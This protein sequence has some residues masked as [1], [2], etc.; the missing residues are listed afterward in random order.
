MPSQVLACTVSE[1][2]GFRY[3]ARLAPVARP[4]HT[5]SLTISS[6]WSRAHDPA[7]EQ[8]ALQL[9]LD[10]DALRRLHALLGEGLARLEADA[11]VM[12]GDGFRPLVGRRSD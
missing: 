5:L 7:A 11:R 12:S 3:T 6:T 2:A 9:N 10:V 1:T 8:C 4:R